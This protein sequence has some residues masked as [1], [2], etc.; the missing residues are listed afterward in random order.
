M[1]TPT[2]KTSENTLWNKV[3]EIFLS[4]WIIKIMAT[5]VG[6]TAADYLNTTLDM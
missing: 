3:P 2:K 5:T 4:F 6:E 1:T